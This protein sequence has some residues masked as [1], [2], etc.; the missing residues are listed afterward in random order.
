MWGSVKLRPVA[1]CLHLDGTFC[2]RVQEA[3]KK[4]RNML[5]QVKAWTSAEQSVVK[6]FEN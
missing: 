3:R 6:L 5:R 4:E 1:D 2:T